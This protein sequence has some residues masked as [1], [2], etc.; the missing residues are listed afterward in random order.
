L[1]VAVGEKK[2]IRFV[3]SQPTPELRIAHCT[4]RARPLTNP[5]TKHPREDAWAARIARRPIVARRRVPPHQ[6]CLSSPPN[7]QPTL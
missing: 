1:D 7:W 2:N 4:V 6:F 3:E 5:R